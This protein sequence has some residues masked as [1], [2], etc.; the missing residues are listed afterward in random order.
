MSLVQKLQ[1]KLSN[2]T[3][4]ASPAQ[5]QE[6]LKAFIAV[7]TSPVGALQP[8]PPPFSPPETLTL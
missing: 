2:G 7:R 5:P 8:P 1:N 6:K 4:D 3:Q